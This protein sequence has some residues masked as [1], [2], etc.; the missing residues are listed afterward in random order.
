M[1]SVPTFSDEERQPPEQARA[2]LLQ[3]ALALVARREHS[4]LELARKL[5]RRK[6]PPGWDAEQMLAL[7]EQV[8]DELVEQRLLSES[9]FAETYVRMRSERGYG[10]LRIRAEL[11]ERGLND[12][13]IESGME[14]AE[15]DWYAL[16]ARTW[17]KKFGREGRAQDFK[18]RARQARFLQ[19]RGFD[20]EQVAHALRAEQEY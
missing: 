13:L 20:A 10:P 5:A 4:R 15:P 16:A 7:R 18:Q 11:R 1:A 9:R 17:E 6:P 12:G 3:A 2:A 8:L 14:A 19:N